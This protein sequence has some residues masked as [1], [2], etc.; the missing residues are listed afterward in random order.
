MKIY[1]SHEIKPF[2][3][4][5]F[6]IFGRQGPGWDYVRSTWL[7]WGKFLRYIIYSYFD[8]ITSLKLEAVVKY[9]YQV[10]G[11]SKEDI[12]FLITHSH[13]FFIA[14]NSII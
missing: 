14:S 5:F 6:S 8:L 7:L 11:Y 9:L 13:N 4:N 10:C 2:I 12:G 1:I 3:E